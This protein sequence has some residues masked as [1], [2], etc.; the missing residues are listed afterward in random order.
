SAS[1]M[2]TYANI[3]IYHRDLFAGCK[4]EFFPL[5]KLMRLA[6]SQ[7]KATGE[8]FHGQWINVGTPETYQAAQAAA[9]KL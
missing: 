2:L 4:I 5:S 3:G 1:N 6:I 7:G 8:H 9:K